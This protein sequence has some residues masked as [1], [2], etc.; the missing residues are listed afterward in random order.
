MAKHHFTKTLIAPVFYSVQIDIAYGF[1]A[2]L[3]NSSRKCGKIYALV[4]VCLHT[5]ATNILALEA[6]DTQSVVFAIERHACRYGMPAEVYVD[7]GSQLKALDKYQ[8]SM[9]DMDAHL[10][11]SRGIRVVIST[12]K[13][14]EE[15]GKVENRIKLLRETMQRYS[16]DQDTARTALGWETVFAQMANAMDDLPIAK[17]NSSNVQNTEFDLLTPNRLKMGRNNYRT[18]HGNSK[19]SDP[20]LPSELLDQNRR[21]MSAFYQTL[22]DNLHYFQTKP[23]KWGETSER[24]PQMDD[25]VLFKHSDSKSGGGWKLGRV[26]NVEARKVTVMYSLRSD[27]KSIPTMKFASRSFRDIVII[28][29]EKEAYP[30]SRDHFVALNE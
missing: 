25:I 4:L 6:I 30:R 23:K 3:Y 21:I 24:T 11:D 9:K 12:P 27:S 16:I 1:T 8:F 20:S 7:N 17:S 13:N 18:F 10:Y 14:H 5:S 28:L 15:R 19:F 29:N 2:K 26:V 22:A